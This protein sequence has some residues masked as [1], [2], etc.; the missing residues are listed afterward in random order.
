MEICRL[1]GIILLIGNRLFRA[2]PRMYYTIATYIYI[3]LMVPQTLTE[4][5]Y[6]NI[7]LAELFGQQP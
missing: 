6:Y 2:R 7:I 3:R 1:F 5:E 4:I